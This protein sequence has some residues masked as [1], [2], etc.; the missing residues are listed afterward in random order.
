MKKE[1]CTFGESYTTKTLWYDEETNQFSLKKYHWGLIDD[2]EHY[3]GESVIDTFNALKM[4]I[5]YNKLYEVLQ[6]YH[7]LET[8]RNLD[9][10]LSALPQKSRIQN[11]EYLADKYYKYY[12]ISEKEYAI[13][14]EQTFFSVTN[15]GKAIVD[16]SVVRFAR[17]RYD[18]IK[19]NRQYSMLISAASEGALRNI[20][21]NTRMSNA[22]ESKI[23]W[24]P[25][26][27]IRRLSTTA[28]ITKDAIIP[29][30]RNAFFKYDGSRVATY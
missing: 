11:Y 10:V 27:R 30:Y 8:A 26:R 22:G 14:Y 3:D 5:S 18:P 25:M 12:R 20:I 28:P 15:P 21:S 6:Y 4:M 2:E 17:G 19:W 29:K 7:V 13:Y 1:I 9:A 24:L 16:F 23:A